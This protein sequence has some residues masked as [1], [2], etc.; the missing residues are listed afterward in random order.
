MVS[1]PASVA[2][3]DAAGDNW[4]R[5]R[6]GQVP[7]AGERPRFKLRTRGF[8]R[9]AC[10]RNRPGRHICHALALS[11]EGFFR[12]SCVRRSHCH[13]PECAQWRFSACCASHY[14]GVVSVAAKHWSPGSC[15]GVDN[16]FV[17]MLEQWGGCRRHHRRTR[18][19]L[20]EVLGQYL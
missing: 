7:T 18:F 5:H 8:R 13:A 2:T 14:V 19:R 16:H 10:V 9:K 15:D 20:E 3:A 1:S 4:E 17:R 12:R 6:T 11:Q